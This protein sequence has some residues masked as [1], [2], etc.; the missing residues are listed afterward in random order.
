LGCPAGFSACADK[1]LCSALITSRKLLIF[2]H[3]KKSLRDIGLISEGD[4]Y[5]GKLRD[6][7]CA[8]QL[9]GPRA[10]DARIAALCVFS[11]D[12]SF[13]SPTESCANSRREF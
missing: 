8:A 6:M 5:L 7:A 2:L 4:G 10:H 13:I 1:Q 12:T 11:L 9:Q 3:E